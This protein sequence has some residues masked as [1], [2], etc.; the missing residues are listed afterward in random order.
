MARAGWWGPPRTSPATPS[1]RTSCTPSRIRPSPRSRRPRWLRSSSSS[2]RS[3]EADMRVPLT[4]LGLAATLCLVASA[5]GGV[6]DTPLPTFSDGKA[7]QLVALLPGVIKKNQV[8]TDVICTNLAPVAVDVG[9][10]VF[11]Q[12][13][14]RGNRVDAGDGAL[15][16]VGPGRTRTIATGGTAGVPAGAGLT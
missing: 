3:P 13:G 2:C 16:P 8:D 5:R 10:E 15:L 1:S 7:A 6:T 4:V 12:G 14:G 11:D 9:F